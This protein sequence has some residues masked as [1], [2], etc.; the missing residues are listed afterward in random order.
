MIAVLICS[1]P[2][3]R[4]ELLRA[5]DADRYFEAL[6]DIANAF[7]AH[8]KYDAEPVTEEMFWAL[9]RENGIELE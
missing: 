3:G 7:R 6:R 5:I 4:A 1:L 9:V 8:R 2:D